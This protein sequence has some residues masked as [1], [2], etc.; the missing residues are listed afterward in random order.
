MPTTK[1]YLKKH[2]RPH[3]SHTFKGGEVCDIFWE[4]ENGEWIITCHPKEADGT[5]YGFGWT[6][7]DAIA[8]LEKAYKELMDFSIGD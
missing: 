2:Q 5:V 1:H 7:Q 8:D 4:Q 3:E 6:K